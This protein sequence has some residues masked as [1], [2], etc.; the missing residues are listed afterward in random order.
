MSNIYIIYIGTPRTLSWNWPNFPGK[1][2]LFQLANIV[3]RF[4]RTE[5]YIPNL[6]GFFTCL[7]LLVKIGIFDFFSSVYSLNLQRICLTNR[8]IGSCNELSYM[9]IL[10]SIIF[11]FLKLSRCK[12][13]DRIVARNS[14]RTLTREAFMQ[15]RR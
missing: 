2:T 15:C 5:H 4:L 13:I 1:R 8:A 3:M 6:I 11:S 7:P 9:I 12:K 14:F 10:Y